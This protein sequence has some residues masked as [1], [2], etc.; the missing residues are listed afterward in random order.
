[1]LVP[2]VIPCELSGDMRKGL[3]MTVNV[4]V[5]L[6]VVASVLAVASLLSYKVAFG[7]A[8]VALTTLSLSTSG[9]THKIYVRCHFDPLV[10]DT[11]RPSVLA[12]MRGCIPALTDTYLHLTS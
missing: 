1:M 3:L 4:I 6:P 10:D 9:T 8:V 2:F 11:F 7:A 12:Q 5:L